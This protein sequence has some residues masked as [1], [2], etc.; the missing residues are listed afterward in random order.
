M[1]TLYQREKIKTPF[2]EVRKYDLQ[3]YH[4]SYYNIEEEW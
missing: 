3:I 2:K 1:V 4:N